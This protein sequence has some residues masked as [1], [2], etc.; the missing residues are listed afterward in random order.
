LKVFEPSGPFGQV[1][2]WGKS[3]KKVGLTAI[4]NARKPLS[5]M[6]LRRASHAEV[7]RV[8]RSFVGQG[9][10][11]INKIAGNLFVQTANARYSEERLTMPRVGQ[12]RRQG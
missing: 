11:N 2:V 1:E 7:G 5:T 4:Q 8:M 3:E 10:G 9:Q 12:K 6:D